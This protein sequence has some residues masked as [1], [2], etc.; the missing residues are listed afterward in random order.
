MDRVRELTGAY[1]A[2]VV[3]LMGVGLFRHG[4]DL[5]ENCRYCRSLVEQ[6]RVIY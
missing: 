5:V 6:L 3:F 1:G 2:G 4:L